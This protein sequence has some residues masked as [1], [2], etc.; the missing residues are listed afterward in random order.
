MNG[1]DVTRINVENVKHPTVADE[2]VRVRQHPDKVTG[3]TDE[4]VLEV[5]EYF[6]VPDVPQ[7][8]DLRLD[9]QPQK[10]RAIAGE[11]D[12]TAPYVCRPCRLFRERQRYVELV[13]AVTQ[14]QGTSVVAICHSK[15]HDQTI[16]G[17]RLP[18]V[19]DIDTNLS[20]DYDSTAMVPDD[21]SSL[22]RCSVICDDV[23][24]IRNEGEVVY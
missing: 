4:T 7:P 5:L 9:E 24:V 21:Q 8:D 6:T 15:T 17:R 20:T 11:L 1:K 19:N 13:V 2:S 16:G 18:N 10:H 23:S 12:V 22:L 3:R 14:N